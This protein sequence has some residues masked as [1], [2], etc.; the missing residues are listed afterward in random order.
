MPSHLT[1]FGREERKKER[2]LLKELRQQPVAPLSGIALGGSAFG[3]HSQGDKHWTAVV[4]LVAWRIDNGPIHQGELKLQ[5][6]MT[7]SGVSRWMKRFEGADQVISM[8]AHVL[9]Q[10]GASPWLAWLVESVRKNE[11]DR[12]LAT[13]KS[14]LARPVR[15]KEAGIGTLTLNR[16]SKNWETKVKWK[17]RPVGVSIDP[18]D[19]ENPALEFAAARDL[20]KFLNRWTAT[21]SSRAVKDYL[22]SYNA[23]W[24]PEANEPTL[25]PQQFTA[26]LS[27]ESISVGPG[28]LA[29][30][31]LRDGDLLG[32]HSIRVP[33]DLKKGK[34]RPSDLIG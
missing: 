5:R 27:P 30:I 7:P 11:S 12:E 14:K 31:C 3:G 19:P 20:V 28:S 17:G 8:K 24:A 23:E 15:R 26:R 16:E 18:K 25:T 10:H 13:L 9:E 29:S 34:A 4:R 22:K 2:A 21:A 6:F 32:G 33:L 1:K